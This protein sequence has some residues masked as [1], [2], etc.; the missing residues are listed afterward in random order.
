ML[1]LAAQKTLPMRKSA[2][3]AQNR[4]TWCFLIRT[5]RAVSPWPSTKLTVCECE[6]ASFMMNSQNADVGKIHGARS[7]GH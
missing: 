3:W 7:K 2:A 5:Y 6:T 4:I 1:V